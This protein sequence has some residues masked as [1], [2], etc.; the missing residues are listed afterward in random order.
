[1]A[2]LAAATRLRATMLHSSA[3]TDWGAHSAPSSVAI[4]AAP[5]PRTCTP[6]R[7]PSIPAGPRGRSTTNWTRSV[8]GSSI[9]QMTAC[10]PKLKPHSAGD[11]RVES[12]P[13]KMMPAQPNPAKSHSIQC[14]TVCHWTPV[15][16]GMQMSSASLC[17]GVGCGPAPGDEVRPS[18]GGEKLQGCG[19]LGGVPVGRPASATPR[20]RAPAKSTAELAVWLASALEGRLASLLL[21]WLA[22]WL[23][24]DVPSANGATNLPRPAPTGVVIGLSPSQ[25]APRRGLRPRS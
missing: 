5:K 4:P 2:E 14:R 22:S 7:P 20:S 11:E 3:A 6:R 10:S 15:P 18:G 21:P 24:A 13:A 25:N 1:M 19:G 23:K 12:A 17:E 9:A 16:S 8:P